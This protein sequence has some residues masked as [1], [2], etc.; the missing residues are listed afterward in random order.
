MFFQVVQPKVPRD[1]QFRF[2]QCK[3]GTGNMVAA[4]WEMYS[5]DLSEA[6]SDHA[7]SLVQHGWKRGILVA[8]GYRTDGAWMSTVEFVDLERGE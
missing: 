2:S 6:R 3:V 8:G 1:Y 5:T 7:C 4:P